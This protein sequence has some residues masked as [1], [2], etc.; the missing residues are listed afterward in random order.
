[1]GNNCKRLTPADKFEILSV[2]EKILSGQCDLIEGCA[3]ITNIIF[4][5]TRIGDEKELL[6]FIGVE[7][8]TDHLP[9]ADTRKNWSPETLVEAEKEKE[10]IA[11]FYRESVLSECRHV[12][13]RFSVPEDAQF[14]PLTTEEMGILKKLMS[15]N[16][17]GWQELEKQL[18]GILANQ[19]D[20]NGSLIL[21]VTTGKPARVADRWVAEARCPDADTGTETSDQITVR[22]HVQKGLLWLMEI[23]K[24]NGKRILRYPNPDE[25]ALYT[26]IP[27]DEEDQGSEE[28]LCA[29]AKVRSLELAEAEIL[30]IEVRKEGV[31]LHRLTKAGNSLADTLHHSI[32]EAKRQAKLEFDNDPSEWMRVPDSSRTDAIVKLAMDD[33]S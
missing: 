13:A 9:R 5:V 14:R 15:L 2:A 24:D 12:I 25:F 1:M 26:P 28:R 31:F 33:F 16:I 29:R 19:I 30:L 11:N 32:E 23:F 8:D 4:G 22:L 18:S 21:K 20:D 3:E 6:F 27:D 10:R 7:S 17:Y